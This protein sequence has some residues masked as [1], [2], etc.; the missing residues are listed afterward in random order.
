MGALTV[1]GLA[2]AEAELASGLRGLLVPAA[3]QVRAK[4]PARMTRAMRARTK[5]FTVVVL[6]LKWWVRQAQ[7]ATDAGVRRLAMQAVQ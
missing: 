1:L 6:G 7:G 4:T 3:H 5:I 2:G